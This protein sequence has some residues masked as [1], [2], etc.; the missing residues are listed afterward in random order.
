MSALGFS[1]ILAFASATV[2]AADACK[3]RAGAVTGA[4]STLPMAVLGSDLQK[5]YAIE[6]LRKKAKDGRTI[7]IEGGDFTDYDFRKAKLH[8]ICFRGAKLTGTDWSGVNAPGIG[9]IDSDLSGATFT[10]AIMR[11]ALFRTTTMANVDATAADLTEGQLDGGWNASIKN[12]KLDLAKLNGFRFLCGTRSVDGCPFDRQGIS[13]RNTDF[14]GAQ[15]YGFALWG[16]NVSGAIFDGA[17]MDVLD[18]GQI[19]GGAEPNVVNVR[20]GQMSTLVDGPV[21][22]ALAGALASTNA[23]TNQCANPSGALQLALCEDKSGSLLALDS[24]VVR[25]AGMSPTEKRKSIQLFERGRNL[26]LAG[27]AD[28]RTSCLTQVYRTR[29]N[30]LLTVAQPMVWMKRAGRV[31]F[32]RNDLALASGA[33]LQPSWPG[34][35]QVLLRLSPSYML[36]R[37]E[38]GK[39]VAVRG[40]AVNGETEACSIEA[41]TT[42]ASAGNFNTPVILPGK[43]RP[44]PMP[45]FKIVGEQATLV[46]SQEDG[47]APVRVAICNGTASF[48]SMRRLPIDEMTFE[49]LWASMKPVTP[50]LAAVTPSS[51]P[52][53]AATGPS[54]P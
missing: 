15:F 30:S 46:T 36:A 45:L 22:M 42:P 17:D 52:A 38:S 24:D 13:A 49:T 16:A 3:A 19:I 21:A 51:V 35:A 50:T 2:P 1:I 39:R 5:S 43:K 12:L 25:L 14:S 54:R 48:G 53:P 11:G 40:T 9:F 27:A 26:C 41:A 28:M 8:N 37:V 4:G 20:Y 18:V 44:A 7:V 6:K 29:R 23:V 10:G 47:T 31:M 33:T 32:A 34:V